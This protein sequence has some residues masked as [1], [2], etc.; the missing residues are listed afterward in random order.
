MKRASV[1]TAPDL[2]VGAPGFLPCFLLRQ[3]GEV[4]R[5]GVGLFDPLERVLEDLSGAYLARLQK[6]RCFGDCEPMQVLL[7]H[8]DFSLPGF[9]IEG[10]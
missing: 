5:D 6:F 2:F 7:R 1:I 8:V 4:A 10:D 3:V 9:Q